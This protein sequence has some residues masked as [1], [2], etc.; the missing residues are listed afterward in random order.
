MGDLIKQLIELI[1]DKTTSWGF[2]SALFFS[3]VGLIFV[4]DYF[5][6]FSYNYHLEH[7]FT[8]MESIQSM[9]KIYR[10]D[11]IAMLNIKSIEKK[12]FNKKHYSE[13]ISSILVK[14]SIDSSSKVIFEE[15]PIDTINRRKQ[16][17]SLLLMILTS[18]YSL[19]IVFFL[20]LYLPLTGP[21]HR[22]G[23]N[24]L[25]WFASLVVMCF[26]M[27]FIT[28][29]AYLIPLISGKPLFNYILNIILHLPIALFIRWF[30]KV[31]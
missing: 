29:I 9:K 12:V 26:I 13:Y 21:V 20:L 17:R 3:I 18:N 6:G 31:K 19:I 10:S 28:W 16:S 25:G 23:E 27:T 1:K 11:S 30:L 2:K 8:Q 7:K 4:A 5:I 22:T 14:D 24:L 15:N